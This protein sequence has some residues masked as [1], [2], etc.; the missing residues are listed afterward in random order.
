MIGGGIYTHGEMS[1]H[2]CPAC[3]KLWQAFL[4]TTT[5]HAALALEQQVAS[6]RDV[7]QLKNEVALAEKARIVALHDLQEH[8]AK[9]HPNEVV[10]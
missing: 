8:T 5:R 3:L 9:R 4:K 2:D 1:L 7:E 10:S 6:T